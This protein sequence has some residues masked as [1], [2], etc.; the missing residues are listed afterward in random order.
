[1]TLHMATT[2]V[3]ELLRQRS[4]AVES[5]RSINQHCKSLDQ[6]VSSLVGGTVAHI[7]QI[8]GRVSSLAE[9]NPADATVEATLF[10]GAKHPFAFAYADSR[11]RTEPR[12]HANRLADKDF[13]IR[14]NYAFVPFLTSEEGH[15]RLEAH[16]LNLTPDQRHIQ[17]VGLFRITS[18]PAVLVVAAS[19]FYLAE[20]ELETII[21]K[22]HIPL[23]RFDFLLA[24]RVAP[25]TLD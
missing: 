8:C 25:I 16:Q 18:L 14:S 13:Y 17:E 11:G 20:S 12:S 7:V 6:L 24:Q 5:T 22:V 21:T 9:R 3:Q 23:L 10:L 2:L 15:A 4:S 19:G 1:M